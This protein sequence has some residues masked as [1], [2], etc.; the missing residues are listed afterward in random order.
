MLRNQ[1]SPS[2]RRL[3]IALVAIVGAL[4]ALLVLLGNPGNMGLCGACFVR[5]IAGSLRLH[6]G[7]SIFRP[8]VA[9]IV[10]GA[11]VW[12]LASGRHVGRS[13]SNAVARFML[14]VAMAIGALLFLGCPFRMLQRLGGGDM[15]AWLALPGF[16]AGV[17]IARLFERRGYSI[18]KT[19]EVPFTIGLI[20]PLIVAILL[21]V[22]AVGGVL[23]GPGP[24]VADSPS[25]ANWLVALAVGASAGA[26]LSATGFCAISAGRQVFGGPRLMLL[27]AGVLILAYALVLAIGGK[28]SL[29]FDGQPIAHNEWLW[30][31]LGLALVGLCGAL[32]GG[33]PVRLVVL[34][35]EGNGDAFV[36]V[37]GLLVGG[38]L[39]HT[40]GLSA[41]PA[42]ALA[43]GGPAFAG[44]V[45]VS[46]GLV[47]AI[48]YAASMTGTFGRRG[49]ARQ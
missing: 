46:V 14:G 11:L 35:G 5:D 18:G 30:N 41:K 37:M 28:F 22:F 20:G 27:S 16:L 17:G 48:A 24:G 15:T 43:A 9:G 10:I 38:A 42:T 49:N 45:A 34:T 33:C 1:T 25:H 21:L 47:L 40:L 13:G 8:E 23:A 12:S 26:L 29:G 39:A 2:L 6:A 7:P 44:K 32:C 31:T 4:A 19:H 36:A 3:G